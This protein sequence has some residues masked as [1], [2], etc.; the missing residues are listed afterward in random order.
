MNL[1]GHL[2][3]REVTKQHTIL[4]MVEGLGLLDSTHTVS[5]FNPNTD[6]RDVS[7]GSSQTFLMHN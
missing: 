5:I 2:A 3:T 4:N 6:Y 1:S 7:R